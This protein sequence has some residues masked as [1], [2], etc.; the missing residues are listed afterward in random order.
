M[1][2]MNSLK[3]TIA[4]GFISIGASMGMTSIASAAPTVIGFEEWGDVGLSGPV[5]TNQY[6]G[7]VFS[8]TGSNVNIVSSQ[9]NIGDGLNF[10]CTGSPGINCVGETILSFAD[11]VSSLSFLAV[12]SNNSGVQALV[13]VFVNGAFAATNNITVGGIFNTPDLV[14]LSA[15][16]D[17][18]SIRIYNITDGG[19]LGWDNFTFTSAV[20]E[21]ETYAM[22]LLGLG[23]LGF[24]AYRRKAIAA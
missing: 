2:T 18:T 22:L 7:V 15:F 20:P 17:V 12:G 11:P 4:A 10:L 13:D 14:D 1:K 5:I 9:P 24:V 8:S 23:L 19:G 6:A 3:R 21:P 16:N